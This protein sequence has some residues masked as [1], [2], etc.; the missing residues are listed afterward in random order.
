MVGGLCGQL[1]WGSPRS[2]PMRFYSTSAGIDPR[3]RRRAGRTPPTQLFKEKPLL[4]V[5]T[6][7]L[8]LSLSPPPTTIA[9]T[10]HLPERHD[11]TSVF[12]THRRC[13]SSARLSS[14]CGES[15]PSRPS[16]AGLHAPSAIWRHRIRFRTPPS[17]AA[18]SPQERL[19]AP[20][21]RGGSTLF[22]R[23]R[24]LSSRRLR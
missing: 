6:S 9:H 21:P 24:L 17:P 11:Q 5:Y 1:A 10:P 23:P 14:F 13:S 12:S 2:C 22:I 3:A 19:F 8:N 15:Q 16:P 7:F 4:S 20:T 18:P